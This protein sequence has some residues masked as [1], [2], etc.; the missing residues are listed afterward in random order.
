MRLLVALDDSEPA[1]AALEFA[2]A[3]HG[4]DDVIVVHA[5]DPSESGYGEFA[6]LGTAAIVERQRVRADALFEAARSRAAVH[7]CSIET[8]TL[9]GRPADAIVG[10][11]ADRGIDRI[12]VGSHGR[13]G[14]SRI[15]LGSVAEG[16][17]RRASVPVTIVG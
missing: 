2:C 15:L 6:H 5:V 13:T 11:A 16:I 12:V 17:A 9:M 7:G 3:E 10:C 14:V 8:E 4:E 1:W